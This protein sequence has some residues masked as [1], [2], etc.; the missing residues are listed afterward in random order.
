MGSKILTDFIYEIQRVNR[1]PVNS[2]ALILLNNK[3][4]NIERVIPKGTKLY[5]SRII[6]AGDKL[7][8]DSAIGFWGYDE[9]GSFI[10]PYQSTRDMRANYRYI[11]YLYVADA[12]KLAVYETRPRFGAEVSLA[13][14]ENIE[15]LMILDFTGKFTKKS[16][17]EK[18]KANLFAEISECFSKPITSEDDVIDYIPTQYIAEYAKRLGYDGI[19]YKSS[20][21]NDAD[22]GTHGTNYTIFNYDKTHAIKSNVL[23]IEGIGYSLNQTDGDAIKVI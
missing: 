20:L 8:A 3:T 11:P 15:D 10:A 13:T 17:E 22:P 18:T 2:R 4:T 21:Y 5:R 14:I 7:G 9:K 19:A 23:K 16:G 1:N 6:C 12:P